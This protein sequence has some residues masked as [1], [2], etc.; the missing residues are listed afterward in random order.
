FALA[1]L[2]Q[3]FAEVTQHMELVVQNPGLR[4][5][6]RLERGGA[7][8]LPHVHHREA[9]FAAFAW[10]QP[11]EEAI[12]ALLGAVAAAEPDR[13]S[14]DQVAD[15]DAVRVSFADADLVD[16]DDGWRGC[17]VTASLLACVVHLQ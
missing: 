12:H 17:P 8:W 2:V 16:A 7:E 1:D 15:D 14:P 13:P 9:D 5:V 10:P 6:A 4:C 11:G 3:R